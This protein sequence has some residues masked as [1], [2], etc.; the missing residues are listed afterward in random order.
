MGHP[1]SG[2]S[3][4]VYDG[5]GRRVKKVVGAAV[6]VFVYDA[7][8]RVVAEYGG[9]QAQSGGVSYVTQ[10]YLGS[11]R[12]VTGRGQEVKGRYDFMPFGEEVSAGRTGY[13]GGGVRQKF[14]QKERDEETGLDF[15]G[16][17]YYSPTAGR[18]STCD[19]AAIDHAHVANPQR[20]NLYV[21]VI[22][23]PVTLYDPDGKKDEGRGGGRVIDVFITMTNKDPERPNQVRM[24]WRGLEHKARQLKEK[25]IRN[26]TVNIYS[27]DVNQVTYQRVERSLSTPDRITVIIGHSM[28]DPG[29]PSGKTGE[30]VEVGNGYI[31]NH[32]VT[33][34][35]PD[36][37]GV[38]HPLVTIKAAT[39]IT[40][41]CFPG[42]SFERVIADKL[43]PSSVAFYNTGG[44][45]GV[46][47][48]EYGEKSGYA[49]VNAL[50][51]GLSPIEAVEKGQQVL[52]NSPNP[53]DKDFD[54]ITP[55]YPARRKP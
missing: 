40:V 47:S 1:K 53:Q 14:T 13:G 48:V 49:I 19:P 5:D 25:G 50:I 43:S 26:V 6:T 28:T 46:T 32:G 27:V 35:G 52:D 54:A 21:F 2:G 10:D 18:F 41:T 39:F 16:A 31:G 12:V 7:S 42:S 15:F 4:Y 22:N 24:F 17:R 51:D 33:T 55:V 3:S 37:K 20:W 11:T 38:D 9:A 34:R 30:G 29:H 36:G 23:S 8:G 45:K 44:A